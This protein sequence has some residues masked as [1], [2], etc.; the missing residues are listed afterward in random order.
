MR[1]CWEGVAPRAFL[2]RMVLAALTRRRFCGEAV[3]ASARAVARSS[4][5]RVAFSLR[6]RARTSSRVGSGQQWRMLLGS[7]VDPE[8]RARG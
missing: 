5:A 7:A 4:A 8:I 6:S 3:A 1:S 2:A